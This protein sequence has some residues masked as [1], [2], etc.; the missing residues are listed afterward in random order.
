MDSGRASRVGRLG[1]FPSYWLFKSRF[2]YNERREI[3]IGE[4]GRDG[5]RNDKYIG[6]GPIHETRSSFSSRHPNVHKHREKIDCSACLTFTGWLPPLPP[7][8]YVALW[9]ITRSA[10]LSLSLSWASLFRIILYIGIQGRIYN[11]MMTDWDVRE[12]KGERLWLYITFYLRPVIC[13][14]NSNGIESSG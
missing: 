1:T 9:L 3:R 2:T 13:S 14:Q 8:I 7:T 4:R 6:R 12:G 10:S 5:F 11:M